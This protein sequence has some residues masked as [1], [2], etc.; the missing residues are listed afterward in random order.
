MI[1]IIRGLLYGDEG[2]GSIVDYLSQNCSDVIKEGG[3][4]A[5]HHIVSRNGKLHRSEQMSSGVFNKGVRTFSSRNALINTQYLIR[6]HV[7]LH[8]AGVND[9]M[10]RMFI[11]SRC[12]IVTPLHQMIGRMREVI[13]NHGSTGM[14]VGDAVKDWK[15][16]GN[17][18]LAMNDILNEEVL[19]EK[20]NMLFIRKFDEAKDLVKN[21]PS[22][23]KLYEIYK[24]HHELMSERML[25]NSYTNFAIAYPSCIV[26]NGEEYFSGLLESENDIVFEGSQGALLDPEFGFVPYVTKM[27]TTFD[28]AMEL[29]GNRI[30][31]SDI[32]R[33]GV[34]RAYSTRHGR[35]PF[36]TEHEKLTESIPD[37]YNGTNSWQGTFR[38]GWFDLVATRYGLSIN[39]GVDSIALTN[40]DRLS[41]LNT[42]YV[43]TS[44][45][46]CGV[47]E[48]KIDKF[49]EYE[50]LRSKVV[51]TGFKNPINPTNEEI[52]KILFDCVPIYEKFNGWKNHNLKDVRHLPKEAIKYIKFLESEDGLNEK[53]SIISV[54]ET[55]E[56]KIVVKGNMRQQK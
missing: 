23:T 39:K 16:L 51:I 9:G 44:Y 13:N 45:K 40:L 42:I 43:C 25:F 29:I 2:K 46:Y 34:V 24:Y 19:K 28:T 11:D 15:E 30:S 33:I 17:S 38:I 4:Q 20:I 49:F 14:G 21:N 52:T 18:V 41:K 53:I 35:G 56:N 47:E 26:Q 22:N 50:Y 27:K 12:P 5:A 48:D 31:R 54:G 10:K 32:S 37:A 55:S 36:V 3:P 8:F 7:M 6:E 1:Y